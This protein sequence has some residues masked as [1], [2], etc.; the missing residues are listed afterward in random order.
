MFFLS[1]IVLSTFI[2]LGLYKPKSR[3]VTGGLVILLYIIFAFEHSD[4]DYEGYI[5]MFEQIT[6]GAGSAT[7]YEVLYVYLT[8]L[9]S[10]FGYTFDQMRGVLSILEVYFIYH[11]ISKYTKRTAFVFALFMVFPALIDAELF[12]FLFGMTLVIYGIPYLFDNGRIGKII[13]LVLVIF[14]ALFHTSCWLFLVYFL[15]LVKDRKQL[16][17][18]VSLVLV[19]GLFISSS[20]AF[21]NLLE[22]LPIREFVIEKYRTGHYSNMTGVMFAFVK[23][24][25]I[26]AMVLWVIGEKKRNATEWQPPTNKQNNAEILNSRI[27]DMNI[28]SFLFLIPMYYSSSSQRL[29]HVIVLFNYIAIANG[30]LRNKLKSY[31]LEGFAVSVLLLLSILFVE[32]TGTQYIFKSH[33]TEGFL[34]NL[35]KSI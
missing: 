18:I 3:F 5:E 25:L 21:F 16:I 34:I 32:G 26:F 31:V 8:S 11:T 12:R 15:L 22:Y 24:V 7:E 13:Y 17:I 4:A 20:G 33:F 1:I 19:V 35:F 9:A 28:I 2:F 14:A 30:Y 27:V 29:V 6:G 23:Q 10:K